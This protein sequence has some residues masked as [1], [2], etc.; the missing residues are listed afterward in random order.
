MIRTVTSAA[1]SGALMSLC[2][3][4]PVAAQQDF[5]DVEIRT[6]LIAPGI[7]VLFGRGGNIAVSYGED[8]TV[9]IDDQYAPLSDRIMAAVADLGASPV[10]YLINTHWHFDHAGGNENFGEAGALIFAHENVR[11]RM[12]SGGTIFGNEIP[13][14]APVALPV[15]SYGQGVTLNRNGDTIDVMFTGGGHTDGDSIV[16]WREDNVVHMGDLFFN[17]GGFP[18]ID[19]SSGG[20]ILHAL[21]SIDAAL[22]MMDGETVVIPGHGPVSDKLGLSAYRARL[23]AMV[24]RV[25]A[26]K[27]DGLSLDQAVTAKP[28]ADYVSEGGGFINQDQFTTFVWTSLEAHGN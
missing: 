3:A 8:G 14:A 16:R 24:D 7:A 21:S 11:A 4:A 18:F 28:L 9:M 13:P 22:R 17:T 10:A 5:S 26:L 19:T 6:E 20:N 1:A 15:V 23:G 25:K 12:V 2:L 27:E